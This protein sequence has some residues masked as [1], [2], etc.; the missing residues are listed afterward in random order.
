MSCFSA[1]ALA[2]SYCRSASTAC[3]LAFA[4]LPLA[5]ASL[6]RGLLDGGLEELRIDLGDDL[7][8]LHAS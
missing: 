5:A 2:R 6:A 1:S 3:A 4:R 8:L 7:A